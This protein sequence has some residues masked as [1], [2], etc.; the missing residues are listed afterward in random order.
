[1]THTPTTAVMTVVLILF[2]G[3][4]V[5]GLPSCSGPPA[6][7]AVK[8]LPEETSR[9]FEKV[10]KCLVAE[11]NRIPVERAYSDGSVVRDHIDQITA[12]HR[13]CER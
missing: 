6:I 10:G 12:L 13:V 5:L 9:H 7:V 4:A 2:A 1:M 3:A 8:T 11:L